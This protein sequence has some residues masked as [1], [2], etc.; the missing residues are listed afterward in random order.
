MLYEFISVNRRVVPA[1]VKDGDGVTRLG[2]D[3]FGFGGTVVAAEQVMP[4][5]KVRVA[6]E[7]DRK[8]QIIIKVIS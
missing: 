2:V 5:T 4:K 7:C 1:C 3:F 8:S 6:F